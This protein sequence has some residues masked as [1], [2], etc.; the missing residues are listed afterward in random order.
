MKRFRLISLL[1]PVWAILFIAAAATWPARTPH[2]AEQVI[3]AIDFRDITV[4]DALRILSEQSGLNIIASE[5]AAGLKTALFLR[6]VRP[7]EV[8]DALS[9]MHNLWYQKDPDS[10]IVRVYTTRE[11]K[12]GDVDAASEETKIFTL[13]YPYALEIAYAIRDLYGERV[14]FA[15]GSDQAE[16]AADLQGRFRRFNI[17]DSQRTQGFGSGGGGASQQNQQLFQNN[18]TLQG[19]GNGFFQSGPR[20]SR[21]SIS[22]RNEQDT[23]RQAAQDIAANRMEEAIISGEDL[24]QQLKIARATGAGSL[25]EE[26]IQ[27]RMSR[28][29]VSVLRSQNKVMV[30]TRDHEA[31]EH[32]RALVDELDQE[33]STLMLEVKILSVDLSDGFDSVF[34]FD[35]TAGD[36]A[37]SVLPGA[38]AIDAA[39]LSTFVNK[40]F[41]AKI[42]ILEREGR[43]TSVATPMLL[44][45]NQEVSRIFL[46]EERPVTTGYDASTNTSSQI[47]G[48]LLTSTAVQPI[49]VPRTELRSVGTTLLLTPN[50]NADGTVSI[51]ILVEQSALGAKASIPLAVT[52]QQNQSQIQDALVDVVNS[53]TFS[54]TVVAKDNSPVAIGGLIDEQASDNEKKVPILGDIPLLGAVFRDTGKQRTR[55]ELIVILTPHVM[56]TPNEAAEVSRGVIEDES[57]HP[58]VPQMG[59]S[60]DIYRNPGRQHDRYKLEDQYK[61]Y[62]TQDDLDEYRRPPRSR[63]KRPPESPDDVVTKRTSAKAARAERPEEIYA[64]LTRVAAEAMREPGVTDLPSGIYRTELAGRDALPLMSN[65]DIEASPVAS[66]EKDGIH[67]TAVYL[68]NR[69][70]SRRSIDHY[71]LHGRWLAA[72]FESEQLAKAGTAGDGTYAYLISTEPFHH[73]LRR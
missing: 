42:Q 52:N 62:D 60:L 53:R 40:K 7:M 51:R 41:N 63:P 1:V 50:I 30:R 8:L 3:S 17:I 25:L 24:R 44:T 43:V 33:L 9:R 70:P 47:T 34:N 61:F 65:R 69:A 67:V 31:L 4:G 23:R 57:I 12:L 48:G 29:F 5:K 55:R 45:T 38:R 54:G 6:N 66:W 49:L 37:L 26:E 68:Q 71:E 15:P 16:I 2:A 18:Q 13:K 35:I 27:R 39:L 72:T 56:K 10:R 20:V 46:G 14:E 22:D 58:N 19:S 36:L 32:I 73:A 11:F 59:G 28:I 21:P 64:E